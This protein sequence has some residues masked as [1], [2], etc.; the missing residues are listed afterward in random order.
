ME[1]T[2]PIIPPLKPLDRSEENIRTEIKVKNKIF[3]LSFSFDKI[4]SEIK[5][6]NPA[7]LP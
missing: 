7:N 3:I 2:T 4:K 6:V 5:T 1:S